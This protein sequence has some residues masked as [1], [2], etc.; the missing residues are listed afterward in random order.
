[1]GE[2][3]CKYDEVKCDWVDGTVKIRIATIDMKYDS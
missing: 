2:L 1:M 3:N